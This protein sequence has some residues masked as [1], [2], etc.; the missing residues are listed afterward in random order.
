VLGGQRALVVAERPGPCE[1]QGVAASDADLSGDDPDEPGAAE[2]EQDRRDVPGCG[3]VARL[4]QDSE[5]D[6]G[7]DADPADGGR[8]AAR[9]GPDRVARQQQAG[10]QGERRVERTR[11]RESQG[12]EREGERN[13]GRPDADGEREEEE[14]RED[15]GGP[16]VDGEALRD[17]TGRAGVRGGGERDLDRVGGREDEREECVPSIPQ[18]GG[19][20]HGR[21]LAQRAPW[22]SGMSGPIGHAGGRAFAFGPLGPPISRA[23]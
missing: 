21:R 2:Q 4:A 11:P 8:A 9:P 6:E 3:R 22:P 14:A 10:D 19:D 16:G 20:R 17:R 23:G 15:P 7:P 12:R 5:A 1:Q 18:G 13:E